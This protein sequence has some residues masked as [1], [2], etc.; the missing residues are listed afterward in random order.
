MSATVVLCSV[1]FGATASSD[2]GFR[3]VTEWLNRAEIR[4]VGHVFVFK[5]W[6]ALESETAEQGLYFFFRKDVQEDLLTNYC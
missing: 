5:E 2:V 3:C 4:K 1:G 6:S